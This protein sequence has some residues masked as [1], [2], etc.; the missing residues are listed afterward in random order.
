MSTTS[1]TVINEAKV[2]A[3]TADGAFDSR[4]LSALNRAQSYW[5]ERLPWRGLIRDESFIASGEQRI[6]L[7]PRVAFVISVG[8]VTRQ[9]HIQPGGALEVNYE[10][11]WYG[12]DGGDPVEWQDAGYQPVVS[13]P[14]TESALRL[15]ASQSES[16]SVLVRGLVQDAGASGTA[17]HRYVVEEVVPIADE[18][19]TD[20]NNSYVEVL[21]VEKPPNTTASLTIKEAEA[22]TT[23][24][25]I[26]PWEETARYR[27]IETVF[28]MSAGEEIR[29]RYYGRPQ[30]I[31]TQTQPVELAIPR[32]F[33][34]WRVAGDIHWIR[35]E[36]QAAQLAWGKAEEILNNRI[37]ALRAHGRRGA[38]LIPGENG[39]IWGD[40]DLYLDLA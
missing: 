35:N 37:N 11:D 39:I 7:P 38:T 33:L 24:A 16:F 1:G 25:R 28:K 26:E 32:D 14:S 15:A 5:A 23:L 40:M 27:A 19:D 30:R 8:D 10:T 4:A 21:A 29:V 13:Q 20:T 17:L 9:R 22:G 18:T 34:V 3:N 12:K 6:I 2:L 31:N 36:A